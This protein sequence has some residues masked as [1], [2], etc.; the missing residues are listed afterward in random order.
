LVDDLPA[1]LRRATGL[2]VT[3]IRADEETAPPSRLVD[4]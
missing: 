4:A 3:H 2:R 1:R